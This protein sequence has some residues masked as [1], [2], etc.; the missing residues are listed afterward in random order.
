VKAASP[1]AVATRSAPSTAMRSEVAPSTAI[2]IARASA[3]GCTVKIFST[4][5]PVARSFTSMPRNT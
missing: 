3:P 2:R 4:L 5:R 1:V